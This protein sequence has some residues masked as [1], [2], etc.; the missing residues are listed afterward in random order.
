MEFTE[1]MKEEMRQI[2][3]G[4]FQMGEHIYMGMGKLNGRTVC[5]AVAY[6]IDYCFRKANQFVEEDNNVRFSHIN[7]IKVG[8][9]SPCCRFDME[10]IALNH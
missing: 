1:D 4:D 2:Y 9:T 7:K 6:K 3:S 5:I 8:E 10:E